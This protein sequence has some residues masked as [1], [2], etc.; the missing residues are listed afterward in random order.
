[1][2]IEFPARPIPW[3]QF[4]ADWQ[5]RNMKVSKL[6]LAAVPVILAGALAG[7][8]DTNK[9]PDVTDNIRK[10]LDQAGYK[11]VSVSQDREK[12][13]VTLMGT[14]PTDGDK[15]QAESIAK[16]G[17]GAQVVSDQIAIRPPGNESDAKT[18]DSDLDKGIEKN[19][20][21]MLVKNRLKKDVQ[22]DVK[23]GVVTLTGD[24][25]SQSRRTQVERLASTVPNVKQVVNELEVK[26]QKASSA[27]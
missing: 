19:L 3:K 11:D 14:V 5:R 26:N 13:V 4:T 7:C 9:S 6:F 10:S 2:F 12:G 16:S 1:M 22:Y 17:A 18:I 15:A 8:S 20:D 23:N 27:S 21:A 24:V 25:P